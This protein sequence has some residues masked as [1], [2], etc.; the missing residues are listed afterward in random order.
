MLQVILRKQ[1]QAFFDITFVKHP[2]NTLRNSWHVKHDMMVDLTTLSSSLRVWL[3][4]T[5]NNGINMTL[6]QD[7]KIR[8]ERMSA[9]YQVLHVHDSGYAKS[10]LAASSAFVP[11][12]S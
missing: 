4:T 6:V 2:I 12:Q 1:L 8:D 9:S 7:E 5:Y 10:V 11:T 3:M